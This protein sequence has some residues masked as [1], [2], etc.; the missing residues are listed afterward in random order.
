MKKNKFGKM[1]L[2]VF[3]TA[4]IW[5]RAD[6]AKTEEFEMLDSGTITISKSTPANIIAAFEQNKTS[7]TLE[8]IVIVGSSS[9]VLEA[10][11]RLQQGTLDLDFFLDITQQNI[12]NHGEH[13]VD[14]AS[15]IKKSDKMQDLGLTIESVTPS[16]IKVNVFE[17]QKKSLDLACFDINGNELKT[18]SIEPKNVEIM[19]PENWNGRLAK[20][21]LTEQD[22][23]QARKSFI[24][25]TPFV[26]I[27]PGKI[28]KADQS[29]KITLYEDD[30][31]LQEYPIP[32]ATLGFIL[33]PSIQG[34][35]KI[36]LENLPEIVRSIT[37]KATAEAK[38]AYEKMPYKL[39]LE[40]WDNDTKSAATGQINRRNVLYNF[41]LEFVSKGEISAKSNQPIEARFKLL[42][43]DQQQPQ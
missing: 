13:I 5:I 29:V 36:Q 7:T 22:I 8:K 38:L 43:V 15:I 9:K 35:Y 42:P 31:Q 37:I 25:E 20:I 3:L 16:E 26:E 33:S 4:L 17:L 1:L 30:N 18:K 40:I 19:L 39:T 10:R 21:E 34:K 6:L 24:E 32:A 2:V 41:P 14:T 27:W 12:T 23:K 28:I 11:K